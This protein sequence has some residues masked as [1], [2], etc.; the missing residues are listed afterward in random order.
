MNQRLTRLMSSPYLII[1]LIVVAIAVLH[2]LS[3]WEHNLMLKK[4]IDQSADRIERI[5]ELNEEHEALIRQLSENVSRFS[6]AT[7]DWRIVVG[8]V[9]KVTSRLQSSPSYRLLIADLE[10]EIIQLR[11]QTGEDEDS[12][13]EEIRMRARQ[14]H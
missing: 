14:P 4:H 6:D 11:R 5:R 2:L 13:N 3:D 7:T 12:L 8:E 9:E 1:A 10:E